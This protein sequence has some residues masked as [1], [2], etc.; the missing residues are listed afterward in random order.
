MKEIIRGSLNDEDATTR[1]TIVKAIIGGEHENGLRAV[2][3]T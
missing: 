2:S 1:L 3:K